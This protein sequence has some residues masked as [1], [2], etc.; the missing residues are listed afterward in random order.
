MTL[1]D[2]V[3]HLLSLP[4]DQQRMCEI[5]IHECMLVEIRVKQAVVGCRRPGAIRTL[6]DDSRFDGGYALCVF[7]QA[8]R[9]Q[10]ASR[11]LFSVVRLLTNAP[12]ASGFARNARRDQPI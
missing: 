4:L 1:R 6:P 5:G 8:V 9:D 7:S 2:V 3:A 10:A 11:F 12:A